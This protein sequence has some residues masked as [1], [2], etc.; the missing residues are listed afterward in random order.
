MVHLQAGWSAFEHGSERQLT[1]EE[2][3]V[4]VDHG[5]VLASELSEL[6]F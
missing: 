6:T 4:Q 5:F 3:P 2:S 1:Y